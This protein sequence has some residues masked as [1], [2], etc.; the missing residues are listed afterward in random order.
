MHLKA[1]IPF[2]I[3]AAASLAQT[4]S[5]ADL[6]PPN[7]EA[8]EFKKLY[9]DGLYFEIRRNGKPIGRHS[10]RLETE[11]DRST[12]R[13]DV[14]MKTRVLFDLLPYRFR[15]NST[16][17]LQDNQIIRFESTTYENGTPSRLTIRPTGHGVALES[18]TGRHIVP[19][20]L[21]PA[22][23]WLSVKLDRA[24]L[25]DA[26]DGTIVPLD[27]RF[28]GQQKVRTA[29]GQV[30]ANHFVLSGPNYRSE[31]W[32]DALGRWVGMK[33]TAPDGSTIEY[34]CVVCGIETDIHLSENASGELARKRSVH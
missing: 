4:T 21:R 7:P 10:T 3:A 1:L 15:Y 5:A 29:S 17:M 13:T 27:I 11:G 19:G 9:P 31:E 22:P 33:F 18:G 24:R 28:N 30:S 25:V 14:E 2:L 16:F 23:H 8:G 12:L 34:S 6:L 32:Y 26:T 20:S